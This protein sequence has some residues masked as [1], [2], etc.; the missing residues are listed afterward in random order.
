M[1]VSQHAAFLDGMPAEAKEDTFIAEKTRLI[2]RGNPTSQ[3]K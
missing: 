3:L 1:P 2:W